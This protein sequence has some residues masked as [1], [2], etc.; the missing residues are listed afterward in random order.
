MIIQNGNVHPVTFSVPRKYEDVSYQLDDLSEAEA[1]SHEAQPLPA[2]RATR[3][4]QQ[5]NRDA[6]GS[7]K[8]HQRR[9][10][11]QKQAELEE[12]LRN[13]E[14]KQGPKKQ[15]QVQMDQIQAYP[16]GAPLPS[17]YVRNTIHVDAKRF[18][19][20]LPVN[21]HPIVFHISVIKN[22]SKHDE[23]NTASLRFNFHVPG[24][25][26]QQSS[27]VF[28]QFDQKPVYVRELTFRSHDV[29]RVKI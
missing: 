2:K 13:G 28:P 10:I 5:M 26:P 9:L 23:G 24:S 3:S 12:R 21:G 19:V 8:A 14:L 29:K 11:D 18:S 25:G 22:V 1:S 15:S 16:E 6:D 17:D 20:V 4:Q 27:M 7:R